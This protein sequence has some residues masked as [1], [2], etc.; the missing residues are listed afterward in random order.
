MNKVILM[1]RLARDPELR[2]GS[3]SGSATC[4]YTLAVNRSY[5]PREGE[6]TADFIRCV[7]FGQRGEFAGKYFRKGMMVA[8]VGE[9]RV[10]SFTGND[11][12]RRY[13]TDVVISE[14]FFAESKA[15]SENRQSGGQGG[16][17]NNYNNGGYGGGNPNFAP[18]A[19]NGNYA[20]GYGNFGG[21][22]DSGMQNNF[23]PQGG[24][25]PQ[26]PAPAGP[27]G[28]TPVDA[29]LEGDEDLPF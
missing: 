27:E 6:E 24:N 3:Q 2:Y 25:A 28:F 26:N 5:R 20:G 12:N 29:T 13:S 18:A 9:L 4:T 15:S 17:N 1:G 11:G 23:A 22:A 8:V 7:A 19:P 10:S 16:Y 21:Y 14:Q